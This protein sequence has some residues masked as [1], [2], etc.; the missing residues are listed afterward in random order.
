MTVSSWL[1]NVDCW[2]ELVRDAAR[3]VEEEAAKIGLTFEVGCDFERFK[4]LRRTVDQAALNPRY[5]PEFSRLDSSNALCVIG[6]AGGEVATMS[7]IRCYDWQHT[8]LADESR[9]LRAYYDYPRRDAP[10]VEHSIVTA[11]IAERISGRVTA[12]GAVWVRPDLRRSADPRSRAVPVS[13]LVSALSRMI[14]AHY[15]NPDWCYATS[16][17][18]MVLNGAAALYG[19][20]QICGGWR[21]SLNVAGGGYDAAL[22]WSRK[23]DVIAEAEAIRRDGLAGPAKVEAVG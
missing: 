19:W 12:H 1:A 5:D 20:H 7:A 17:S 8:T 6:A 9:T 11:P 4:A 18:M 23:A 21:E 16:K 13:H 10:H 22:M 15:F 3:Q 14:A 2:R